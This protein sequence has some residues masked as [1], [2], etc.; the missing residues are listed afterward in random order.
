MAIQFYIDTLQSSGYHQ[1]NE[2]NFGVDHWQRYYNIYNSV[3]HLLIQADSEYFAMG[4]KM[5]L[6]SENVSMH[7]LIR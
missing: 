5:H 2:I 1:A 4:Q 7:L 6:S 3:E